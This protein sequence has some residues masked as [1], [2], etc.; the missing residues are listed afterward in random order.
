METYG[1]RIK[2]LVYFA[3]SCYQLPLPIKLVENNNRRSKI[4]VRFNAGPEYSRLPTSSTCF[5]QLKLP[6]VLIPELI[7]F[8]NWDEVVEIRS[9]LAENMTRAVSDSGQFMG[10]A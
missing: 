1:M 2:D 10:F 9:T 3:T 6:W 8:D 5:A 7:S 4:N